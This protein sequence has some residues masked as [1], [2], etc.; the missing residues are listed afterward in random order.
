M[1]YFV[2]SGSVFEHQENELLVK[3]STVSFS[4]DLVHGTE[5]NEGLLGLSC[6]RCRMLA[7]F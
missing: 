7:S 2:M 1:S 4:D 5:S 6:G 3:L